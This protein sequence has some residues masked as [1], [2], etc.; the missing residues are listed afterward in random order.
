MPQTIKILIVADNANDAELLVHEL[1][2]A[3]FNPFWLRVE[4]ENDYANSLSPELDLILSD[5][6]MAQFG[7]LRALELLK[8]SG[9]KIPFII[10]SST[11]GAETAVKAIQNGA[12]DYLPKEA[13]ASLGPIV[14]HA[15]ETA[16]KPPLQ[17]IISEING[18]SKT[19]KL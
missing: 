16:E 6:D 3:G 19:G 7:S 13:I 15:V 2:R 18:N 4:T 1:Y 11:T 9:L 17:P 12:T 14:R 10:V 8:Q 5:C